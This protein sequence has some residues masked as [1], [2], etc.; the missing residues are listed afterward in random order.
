[1]KYKELFVRYISENDVKKIN[2]SN[3]KAFNII[4]KVY[5]EHG[6]KNVLLSKK[7]SIP[8]LELDE[9]IFT[10]ATV[11]AGFI[12]SMGIA[13]VKWI[14]SNFNNPLNN[15]M[16]SLISTILLNDSVNFSTKAIIQGGMT[17][18]IRTAAVTCVGIKYF[19]KNYFSKMTIIGAG[20]Q[21]YFQIISILDMY[22]LKKIYIFD[23]DKEKSR[24]LIQE[25]ERKYQDTKFEEVDLI[26][27]SIKES[28]IIITVTSAKDTSLIKQEYLTPGSL[29]ISLG[30]G[31][32]CSFNVIKG[33]NKIYVDNRENCLHGS[34]L[35]K[36]YKYKWIDENI[37]Y[38]DIGQVV[39]G[40]KKGRIN[41]IETILFIPL[42]LVSL[43][44]ALANEIFK[45]AEKKD[46]G[47]VLPYF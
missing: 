6:L 15:N 25:M 5:K 9:S 8:M 21:A 31:R 44:L 34:E 7:E 46:L 11:M 24:K 14:G 37:I 30:A 39:C 1:M 19:A 23:K 32:E 38:G 35:G 27:N 47:E 22:K 43:D 41:D 12:K 20:Y 42:G 4:E 33:I 3:R 40:Q 28:E 29:I 18:A 10:E 45:I 17:T 36:W 2:I 13:G 16:P 26:E